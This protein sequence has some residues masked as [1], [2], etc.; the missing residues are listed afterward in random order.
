MRIYVQ[1][2]SSYRVLAT[3]LEPRLG[4]PVS[5]FAINGWVQELGARSKTPLEVSAQLAPKWGGFLGV[6]G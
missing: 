3:V 6:D 2:L 4:R 5:R 1:G